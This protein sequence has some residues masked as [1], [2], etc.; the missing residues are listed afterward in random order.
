VAAS[1][2]LVS[3]EY[4]QKLD[5]FSFDTTYG[6]YPVAYHQFGATVGLKSKLKLVPAAAPTQGAF[7]LN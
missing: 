7:F 3:C 5:A 4:R 2:V 1:S 6:E